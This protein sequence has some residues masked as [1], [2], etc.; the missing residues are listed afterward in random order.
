M[1]CILLVF[2]SEQSEEGVIYSILLISCAVTHRLDGFHCSYLVLC[3]D[4]FYIR[5]LDKEDYEKHA[6][7]IL[8]HIEIMFAGVQ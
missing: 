5:W 7:D 2:S 3:T 6:L 1:D 8:C 4:C